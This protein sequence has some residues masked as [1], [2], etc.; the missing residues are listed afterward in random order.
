MQRTYLLL[1]E[2]F[3]FSDFSLRSFIM[4][5]TKNV[6]TNL[7]KNCNANIENRTYNDFKYDD[8]KELQSYYT[9]LIIATKFV[10]LNIVKYLCE[11]GADT[12]ARMGECER[13]QEILGISSLICLLTINMS[14]AY[15]LFENIN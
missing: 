14:F 6:F 9:P 2:I 4:M 12:K 13:P 3:R 5:L 8:D 15:I 10:W 11:K 1:L 7:I